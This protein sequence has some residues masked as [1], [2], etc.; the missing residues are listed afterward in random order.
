MVSQDTLDDNLFWA[1][2]HGDFSLVGEHSLTIKVSSLDYAS[3]ITPLEVKVSVAAACVITYLV[4]DG[5]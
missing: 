3:F 5:A 2:S 1:T 4:D